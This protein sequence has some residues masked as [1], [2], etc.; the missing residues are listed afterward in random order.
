MTTV[1][2]LVIEGE[3][4]TFEVRRANGQY[5]AGN[6][7]ECPY[8]WGGEPGDAM[9]D[10]CEGEGRDPSTILDPQG[11]A[12]WRAAVAAER[13]Q[14]AAVCRE[15]AAGYDAEGYDAIDDGE[16]GQRAAGALEC[17]EAIERGAVTR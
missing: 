16:C 11:V 14:C 10:L 9:V 6:G 12:I 15:V 1:W 2:G 7:G 3:M 17:A 13:A 4:H 5:R 8:G